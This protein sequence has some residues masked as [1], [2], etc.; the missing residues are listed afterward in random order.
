MTN[1]LR[2]SIIFVAVA[3]S[4]AL[5]AA[6]VKWD[7]L[8]GRASTRALTITMT[9]GSNAAGTCLHQTAV[10][11]TLWVKD[12]PRILARNDIASIRLDK[13]HKSHC[14][15]NIASTAGDWMVGGLYSLESPYFFLAPMF[16]A[17][18]PALLVGGTPFCAVHDL[19]QHLAGSEKITII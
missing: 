11:I 9:D 14:L 8:C 10:N 4:T 12:Q 17:G 18:A 19:I 2:F 1:T 15:A 16:L 13:H 6:D 3:G 7:E 5:R